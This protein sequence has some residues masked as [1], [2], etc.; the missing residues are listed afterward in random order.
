[1]ATAKQI[2]ADA[3]SLANQLNYVDPNDTEVLRY[4]NMSLQTIGKLLLG[5]DPRAYGQTAVLNVSATA[6]ETIEIVSGSTYSVANKT[7]TD[8]GAFASPI[9]VGGVVIG[10][11]A[12]ASYNHNFFAKV[13]IRTDN[14]LTLDRDI[15]YGLITTPTTLTYMVFTPDL[16]TQAMTLSVSADPIS[17]IEMVTGVL[18]GNM[19][20]KNIDE[21]LTASSNPNLANQAVFFHEGGGTNIRVYTGSGVTGG[22]GIVFVFYKRKPRNL[23]AMTTVVDLPQKYHAMLRDEIARLLIVREGKQIPPEIQDPMAPLAAL[24]AAQGESV[25]KSKANLEVPNSA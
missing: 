8:T 2:C 4:A 25:K 20:G 12:D 15:G 5:V 10:Y 6:T 21:F 17:R 16:A 7:I 19:I 3:R 11:M 24:L 18:C 14:V 13:L 1:M 9:A 23:A 22:A